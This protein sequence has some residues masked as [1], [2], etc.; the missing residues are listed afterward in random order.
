M[1]GAVHSAIKS[2]AQRVIA[3]ASRGYV[4][5]A[6]LADARRVADA[7]STRGYGITLAYWDGVGED[8]TTVVAHHLAGIHDLAAHAGDYVSVKA[9]SFGY[10]AAVAAELVDR[11]SR[12]GVGVH[13]DSLD[14]DTVDPTLDLIGSLPGGA[15]GI[16]VTIP[17]RWRRS[18]DDAATL[19]AM[20]AV[21]RVVKGQWADPGAPELDSAEGFLA[22]VATLAGGRGPVRIA[23]HDPLVAEASLAL[24]GDAGTPAEVELL[25][26]LPVRGMLGIIAD[27]SLPVRVY[28]PYGHG[29][30]PYALDGLRRSPRLMLR[31]IRDAFGGRYLQGF[32]ERSS[33]EIR[34]E[35]PVG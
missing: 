9:P 34:P 20:G 12:L 25:Y 5:G 27:P 16:G 13:F 30:L 23:T 10:D 7:L 24:L 31:L 32:P 4:A 14:H 8:A 26:G 3:R 15:A 17:G 28:V 11:A 18:P 29:W 22:V 35:S 1:T 6:D 2:G 33:A 21:V 19:A